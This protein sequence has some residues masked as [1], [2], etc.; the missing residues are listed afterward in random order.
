MWN[1]L[2]KLHLLENYAKSMYFSLR[3]YFKNSQGISRSRTYSP[4]SLYKQTK[5]IEVLVLNMYDLFWNDVVE[6][7]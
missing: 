3:N 5:N 1:L 6:S 2:D 7:I 4:I